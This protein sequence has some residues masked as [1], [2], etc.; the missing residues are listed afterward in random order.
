MSADYPRQ[1][2][3]TKIFWGEIAPC[4]HVVQI[5]ENDKTFLDSL[6][7]FVAGGIK[8]GD[9][10]IVIATAGHLYALEDRLRDHGYDVGAARSET[11]YIPL[12]AE[13]IL[14]KFM[15]EGWP[16]ETLFKKLVMELI[17]LGN[18]RRMRAFGEMVALLWAQ[19]HSGATVRLEHFW[20]SI[21]QSEAFCVFCAY[22]KSGF[23]QDAND[24]IKNICDAHSR[25]IGAWTDPALETL[26]EPK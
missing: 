9:S 8:S 16:D 7:E 24:S 11:K 25:V 3:P 22:P 10:V 2:N 13:E 18:G 5:Y 26:K 19:G 12:E 20:N 1:Q 14:A 4:E 17:S 21:C 15:V 23:T 6:E